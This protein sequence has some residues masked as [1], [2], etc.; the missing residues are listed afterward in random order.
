MT[1]TIELTWCKCGPLQNHGTNTYNI[2]VPESKNIVYL[3]L[4]I[5]KKYELLLMRRA[6]ASVWSLKAQFTPKI[7]RRS[8]FLFLHFKDVQAHRCWYRRKARQQCLL[9]QAASLCLS[10]TVLT[11]DEIIVVKQRF[12]KMYLCLMLSSPSGTKFGHEETRD[13]YATIR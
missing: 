6:T 10:A 8:Q 4:R 2:H 1:C 9:W 12:L 5:N 3:K 7:M 13:S 11:L